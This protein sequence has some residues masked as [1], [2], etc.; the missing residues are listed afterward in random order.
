[1]INFLKE[2]I[3]LTCFM[4][5]AGCALISRQVELDEIN[6][7]SVNNVEYD[8]EFI[9]SS[10]LQAHYLSFSGQ[11][12]YARDIFDLL[13]EKYPNDA[14]VNFQLAR[15]YID[16]AY[17]TQ[18]EDVA[19]SLLKL[20]E[21]ALH[22]TIDLAPDNLQAKKMIA[23]VYVE[24]MDFSKAAV[25][26]ENLI[27]EDP[28]DQNVIVDLARIYIFSQMQDK[29]ILLLQPILSQNEIQNYDVYKVFALA[30]AEDGQ[31][32][33]AIE[34]YNQYLEI[35]PGEF[36]A[37]YNVALCHFRNEN[38]D[39]AVYHLDILKD[40]NRMTIDVAELYVDVLRSQ[41]NY[42][43]AIELLEVMRSDPRAEIAADIQ[44]GQIYLMT[45]NAESAHMHFARAVSK[46]PND[47][48]A[49]F[50]AALALS[51]MERYY[52]ALRML[53]INLGDTPISIAS[54]DLAAN[55]LIETEQ[56]DMA[57][58][59]V[60]RLLAERKKDVRAYLI[61]ANIFEDLRRF[62]DSVKVLRQGLVVFPDNYRIS[63]M[64]AY[65]LEKTSEWSE[66]IQIAERLYEQRPG[67]PNLA[68]FIGYVLADRNRE[69]TR[70]KELIKTAVDSEPDNGAYLDS[71]AWVYYR[72]GR[73][74][75]AFEKITAAYHLLPDDPVVTEHFIHIC[76]ALEKLENAERVLIDALQKFPENEGL[77]EY[78][79][80]L[81][82]AQEN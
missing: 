1:M 18:D 39:K 49:T 46:A 31:L 60:D 19:L 40:S 72:L 6:I 52:E 41:G 61:S 67:D 64:L 30:C 14:G 2:L 44:I 57:L 74:N 73:Y 13:T 69:L 17:R 7:V 68:N 36:E 4:C 42:D 51:E 48:R 16:L 24:L 56:V 32:E 28:G 38:P 59:L 21:K 22:K 43:E 50:L 8:A 65:N 26:L 62:K 20:T 15:F 10:I 75:E 76:I 70:A 29:A 77:L 33:L 54:A 11:V 53:E 55:I 81:K 45:E 47:R 5:F 82:D 63:I 35:F 3:V 37:T 12:N 27:S 71:L 9:Y 23:D 79:K 66:A 58:M 25:V 80:L 34:A 78:K